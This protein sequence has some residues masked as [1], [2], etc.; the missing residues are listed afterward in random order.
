MNR[1]VRERRGE[2][3]VDEAMLIDEG[4]PVKARADDRD[5]EVIASPGPVGDG[6]LAGVGK[7]LLK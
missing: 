6:E 5:V 3:V 4:K 2:R 1:A 7:G